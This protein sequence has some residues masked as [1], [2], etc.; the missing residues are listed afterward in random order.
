VLDLEDSVPGKEKGE[1]REQV[2][3]SIEALASRSRPGVMVRVNPLGTGLT[4]Y[5]LDAVVRLGLDGV[6]IPKIRDAVDIAKFDALVDH[7][8]SRFGIGKFEYIVAVETVEAIH[9]ARDIA[10][11]SPRVGA[12]VGPSAVHADIARA[13]GY[14]WTPEGSETLYLRSRVLLACREAGIHP[15]TGLWEDLD[16]LDGLREFAERGRR[17]GYRGMVVIHP[18]HVAVI[19]DV[20][21]PGAETLEFFQGMIDAYETAAG[22]GIGA[23]RYR[24]LH[25]DRAHYERA[26]ELLAVEKA[27]TGGEV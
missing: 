19:N 3:Q 5:D 18:K 13:V 21:T 25:I 15:L 4:G 14:E 17:L 2:R 12:M 16:N 11:C 7:F 6:F 22:V 10:R 1:A 23:V 27:R 8:T 24:G 20:F 26:V 9:N